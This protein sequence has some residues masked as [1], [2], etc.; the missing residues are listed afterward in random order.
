MKA[1]IRRRQSR[2][3]KKAEAQAPFFMAAVV[4]REAPAFETLAIQ[5]GKVGLIGRRAVGVTLEDALRRLFG[6]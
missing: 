2:S 4:S 1:P 5:G 6:E 3:K